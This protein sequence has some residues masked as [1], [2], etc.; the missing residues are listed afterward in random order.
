MFPELRCYCN[1]PEGLELHHGSVIDR[2]EKCQKF[3]YSLVADFVFHILVRTAI[4][5]FESRT[6]FWASITDLECHSEKLYNCY[7]FATLAECRPNKAHF[8]HPTHQLEKIVYKTK[9]FGGSM[10][11]ATGWFL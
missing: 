4:R 10:T 6:S 5:T 2:S 8:K 1:I 3:Y 11:T 7:F 9:L